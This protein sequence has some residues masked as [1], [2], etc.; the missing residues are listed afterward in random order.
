LFSS[1]KKKGSIS[2][3]KTIVINKSQMINCNN[4]RQL[5]LAYQTITSLIIGRE[6]EGEVEVEVEVGIYVPLDRLEGRAEDRFVCDGDCDSPARLR[7]PD[8]EALPVPVPPPPVP[9]LSRSRSLALALLAAVAVAVAEAE[10][11]A[12]ALEVEVGGLL[13]PVS[14]ACFLRI[15]IWCIS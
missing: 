3:I 11:L 10:A 12:L 8:I 13:F 9:P 1:F 2:M 4:L 6:G 5:V 14:V 15:K 7:L